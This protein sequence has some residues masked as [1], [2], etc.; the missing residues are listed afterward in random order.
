MDRRAQPEPREP[1]GQ[2]EVPGPRDLPDL[3]AYKDRREAQETREPAGPRDLPGQ[4]E[5]LVLLAQREP[6]VQP[7]QPG[8]REQREVPGPRDLPDL[9]AY[10]VR[11]E[12]QGQQE[13]PGPRDLPD[14]QAYKDRRE[15]Q[16]ALDKL[17]QMAKCSL[18]KPTTLFIRTQS[19]IALLRSVQQLEQVNLLRQPVLRSSY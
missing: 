6:Q 5:P 16:V 14:L 3:Q 9:P 8:L 18:L 2:R 13:V 10:K 15:P 1:Q 19:L 4:Q 17:A 11:R 7:V 12:P